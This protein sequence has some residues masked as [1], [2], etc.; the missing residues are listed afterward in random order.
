MVT[1]KMRPTFVGY[2]RK[3]RRSRTR[4]SPR[5]WWR[6]GLRSGTR[7]VDKDRGLSE[8]PGK[9]RRPQTRGSHARH[10]ASCI[11]MAES[12]Q[13][14]HGLSVDMDVVIAGAVLHDVDKLLG[15][16]PVGGAAAK[17]RFG[18]LLPMECTVATRCWKRA[19]PWIWCIWWFPIPQRHQHRADHPRGY[20]RAERGLERFR[21]HALRGSEPLAAT[22]VQ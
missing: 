5:R 6:S 2:S 4:S 10:D 22:K 11:A 21:S 16:G 9:G 1:Q 13:E 19:C 8:E 3:S 15:Y 18:K 7:A 20:H 14:F 12:V 17:T